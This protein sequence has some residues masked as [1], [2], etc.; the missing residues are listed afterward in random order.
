M[1]IISKLSTLVFILLVIGW[2]IILYNDYK[3]VSNGEDPNFCIKNE[4]K[5]YTDGS[6]HICYG[7]G[8]KVYKYDRSVHKAIE[9]GPI[10]ME[11]K[12]YNV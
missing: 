4:I 8:Y 1:K 10:W 3:K 9:F 11:E 5:D 6:V 12:D 7:L 2:A